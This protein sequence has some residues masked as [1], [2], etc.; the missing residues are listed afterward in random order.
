MPVLTYGSETT[1]YKEKVSSRVKAEQVD[2]TRELWDKR[3]WMKGLMKV[4]SMFSDGLAM[5]RE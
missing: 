5:W 3:G 2:K 4:F 1:L